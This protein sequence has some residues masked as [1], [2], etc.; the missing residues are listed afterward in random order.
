MFTS[1]LGKIEFKMLFTWITRRT[2]LWSS[3]TSAVAS[4]DSS[5]C[6]FNFFEFVSFLTTSDPYQFHSQEIPSRANVTIPVRWEVKLSENLFNWCSS[7]YL[8]FVGLQD[9]VNCRVFSSKISRN[10]HRRYN[11]K[12]IY[13]SIEKCS[14]NGLF[15]TDWVV[16]KIVVEWLCLQSF[17]CSHYPTVFSQFVCSHC[18]QLSWKFSYKQ[19][20]LHFQA[21]QT[22][23]V[24][25]KA[26]TT[27]T[28]IIGQ[29]EFVLRMGLC[30]CTESP[31][32]LEA[33]TS[34]EWNFICFKDGIL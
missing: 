22:Q 14:W 10:C 2:G 7:K 24:N 29:N 19:Q 4:F 28:T 5:L 33:S 18:I 25:T 27:G 11:P 3:T 15:S 32:T 23:E 13:M 21:Q 20:L 30:K 31:Y 34:E 9:N 16:L 17:S 12:L 8:L 26:C 6:C 1:T